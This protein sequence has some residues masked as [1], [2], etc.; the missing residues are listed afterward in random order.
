MNDP[1]ES[2]SR[3]F[4]LVLSLFLFLFLSF[5][6]T[7]LSNNKILLEPVLSAGETGDVAAA[8][9]ERFQES[10]RRFDDCLSLRKLRPRMALENL[11][12]S[13]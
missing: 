6:L 7:F 11:R 2:L 12:V 13:A 1:F 3:W 4:S 9:S 10:V 5:T 8:D